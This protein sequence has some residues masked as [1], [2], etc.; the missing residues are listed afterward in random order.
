M[1]DGLLEGIRV[2]ESAQLFNGDTLGMLL[3]D[4][5]ADVVKV[6]S[7]FRGDYL[8]DFLGQ[9]T[10]HHS[11]AHL[12]VNRNKR[13]LTL[14]L[15]TEEGRAVFW[16]LLDRADVFVD[17]NSADACDKLG[18]GYEA[19]RAHRPRI[20][21]CQ[22][23]GFGSTGPYS[24]IPTHGQMMGASVGAFPL[25]VGD[26]GAV[27]RIK[28]ELYM[29]GI[30]SGGEGTAAG[31]VYA[32]YHIAAALV[33]RERTG[34]GCFID[35]A[36]GE[37]VLSAAWIGAIYNLNDHRITD[38]SGLMP[39][40][41]DGTIEERVSAKYNFYETQDHR[42]LLFCCIEHKFWDNFCKA[43]GREDLLDAKD[44]A[45]PVDFGVGED[46]DWL[47]TELQ[48]IFRERTQAQWVE[49]AATHD[50]ALGPAARASELTGDPHLRERGTIVETEHPQ[51]GSFTDIMLPALVD[52]VRSSSL[53]RHAPALGEQTDEVLAELG[54][55]AADVERMRAAGTV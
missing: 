26:D 20:V 31:A 29:G 47:R 34:I 45:Q 24:T 10:P 22:C 41:P 33:R 13:S 2:V 40:R 17:G 53:R 14:D 50:I 44:E 15:R 51:A 55:T 9:I 28:R 23:T 54:Y 8:R 1:G 7:P 21:Y 30:A 38:R 43:V 25:E 42:F 4:L 39:R 16:R 48:R 18:I 3:A 12:H 6:E 46:S 35:V 52:G 19:Q 36:A 27:H 32:A 5:G 49:L 37:A 11:P